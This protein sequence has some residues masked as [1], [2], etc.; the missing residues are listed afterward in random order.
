MTAA[1][2]RTPPADIERAAVRGAAWSGLQQWATSL[3]SLAVFIVLG[4]LLTPTAFG[5]VASANVVILLFRVIVDQGFSRVLVQRSELSDSEVDTAFWTALG[6]GII[7]TGVVAAS[8]PAVALLFSEPELTDIVRALSP[9]FLLSALDSTQSALLERAMRFRAQAMRRVVAVTVSAAV[10]LTLAAL[11]AGVWALVGQ[12]LTLEVVTVVLLWSISHWRPSRRF[13]TTRFG[14]LFGFGIRYSGIRILWY[15]SQN[16][17]NFLI[18]VFLGPVAL[19][20]YVV[21]YRVFVVVN[22]LVV[23]TINR[24]ALTTFARLQGDTQALNQ[25][26]YRATVTTA[27]VGFP[28]YTGLAL[29]AAALVPLVFGEKWTPSVPVLEALTL[30]GIVQCLDAFTHNLVVAVGRVRNELSWTAASVGALL[31]AFAVSV[32]FGIVVV[33]L[34]LGVEMLVAWPV[35]IWMIRQ[36]TGISLRRYFGP[37]PRLIGATSVMSVA[38]LLVGGVLGDE[39]RWLALVAQ[40]LTGL[41]VYPVAL[42]VLAPS[43]MRD[44][45]GAL[46]R[47]R[48]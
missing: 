27:I 24:V 48:R 30:A 36:W 9:I 12:A 25:A 7:F 3:V 38:V 17:D 11:G 47:L 28:I 13:S 4:R 21:A 39:A 46:T 35:R 1:D 10:A 14:E 42:R 22:E 19:G 40:I 37:Y 26:F 41:L 31:V 32:P 15:L 6:T 18:G 8:A 2:A 33:A 44:L 20:F 43:E 5:L 34:A 23:M 29:T 45:L 16:G